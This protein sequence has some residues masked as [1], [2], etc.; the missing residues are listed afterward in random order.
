MSGF[1]PNFK[2]SMYGDSEPVFD[3]DEAT[4]RL[5]TLAEQQEAK[6][7]ALSETERQELL[8]DALERYSDLESLIHAITRLE[9]TRQETLF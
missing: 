6:L 1:N 5:A 7:L 3:N 8:A 2:V 9:T 4:E